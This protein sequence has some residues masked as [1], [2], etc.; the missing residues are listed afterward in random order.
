MFASTTSHRKSPHRTTAVRWPS[1]AVQRPLPTSSTRL[2]A[3]VH[4]RLPCEVH[5][6]VQPIMVSNRRGG[7]GCPCDPTRTPSSSLV[8]TLLA[9]RMV[10]P[11]GRVRLRSLGH[12]ECR[13]HRR[14]AR[15]PAQ[16]ARRPAKLA[17]R[18]RVRGTPRLGGHHNHSLACE[19]PREPGGEASRWLRA[20]GLGEHRQPLPHRSGIVVHDVVDTALASSRSTITG[21]APS[22]RSSSAL[23]GE[24]WVPITSCPASI[25]WGTSR[26][27]I[28]PLAPVRKI[29]IVSSFGSSVTSRGSRGSTSMTRYAGGT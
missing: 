17:L 9:G 22:V 10:C 3:H 21:F 16:I 24:L 13:V 1:L 7:C 27:P 14:E 25:N 12:G 11:W 18:L 8:R 28:A 19:Q 5:Q 2:A 15:A 23:D 20:E 6:S 4:L 26:L 29:R